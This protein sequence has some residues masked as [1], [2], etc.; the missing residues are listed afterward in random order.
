MNNRF[1]Q[2]TRSSIVVSRMFVKRIEKIYILF[3]RKNNGS[4]K[5]ITTRGIVGIKMSSNC[6]SIRWESVKKE[7]Q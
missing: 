3:S 5:Q 6:F 7:K 2:A 1:K 4:M